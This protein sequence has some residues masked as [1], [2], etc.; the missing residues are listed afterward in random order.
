MTKRL[1]R[2]NRLG[3]GELL[4]ALEQAGDVPEEIIESE[5]LATIYKADPSLEDDTGRLVSGRKSSEISLSLYLTEPDSEGISRLG[6]IRGKEELFPF[7]LKE[8]KLI[9]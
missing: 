1:V 3:A 5:L 9:G 4:A 7:V 2:I 6:G 8:L